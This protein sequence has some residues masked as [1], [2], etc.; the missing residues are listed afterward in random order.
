MDFK[1]IKSIK[2]E[3]GHLVGHFILSD[4]KEGQ[5]LTLGNTLRRVLLANIEGT[6]ITAIKIPGCSNEFSLIPYIREDILEILLNLKEIILSATEKKII[7][8]KIQVKGP[9]IITANCI[10]FDKDV[11]II[12]PNQYIATISDTRL[13]EFDII[14]ECGI[15]YRLVDDNKKN[16][17]SNFLK[18]DAIFMPVINANYIINE[19]AQ[20]SNEKIESL[21]LEIT[22]NGSIT[23]EK[24]LAK[25]VEKLRLWFNNLNFEKTI[26]PN[27]SNKE[28]KLK[29]EIILIEELELPARAY[30]CLKKSGI[31]TINDLKK[32]SE[33]E[34]REIKKLGKKS[35]DGVFLALK[36]KCNITLD[37][38]KI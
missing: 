33:E 18:I 32:Y 27:I 7:S 25:A 35:A 30:N 21:R 5:A 15:G 34:I 14:A 4:L 36:K 38:L 3:S 22:T 26:K 12:N 1:Y 8:G 16:E 37:A 9:G 31:E 6:A 24:A 13:I 17:T 28:K 29:K 2:E 23:P 19:L 20:S 11:K 10:E